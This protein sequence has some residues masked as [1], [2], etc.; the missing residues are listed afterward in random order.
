MQ[1]GCSKAAGENMK[2]QMPA[3]LVAWTWERMGNVEVCRR[4]IGGRRHLPAEGGHHLTTQTQLATFLYGPF[5]A[6]ILFAHHHF[7]YVCRL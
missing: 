6:I 7:P 4:G 5:S 2:Q 1:R 3:A